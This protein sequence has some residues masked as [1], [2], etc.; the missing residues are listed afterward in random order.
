MQ[1]VMISSPNALRALFGFEVAVGL[2]EI[3]AGGLE[4]SQEPLRHQQC[5]KEL[6]I[7]NTPCA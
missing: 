5:N 7:I 4:H 6:E 3:Q 1:S 2:K